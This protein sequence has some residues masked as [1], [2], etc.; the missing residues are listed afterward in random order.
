MFFEDDFGFR[1]RLLPHWEEM[2]DELLSLEPTRFRMW[3]H[4]AGHNGLWYVFGLWVQGRR[5]AASCELCPRTAELA[6]MIPGLKSCGFSA[7]APGARIHPHRGPDSD[8]LRYHIGLVVPPECGLKVGEETRCWEEGQDL[9]FDDHV[10]HSAWN[11]GDQ[12]RVIFLADF[13]KPG[14]LKTGDERV[15]AADQGMEDMIQSHFPDWRG[16]PPEGSPHP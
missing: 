3:P 12:P 8:F 2:R 1:R 16:E 11:K 4:R 14:K 5:I 9:C 15:Q 13:A 6:E 7:L 10:R